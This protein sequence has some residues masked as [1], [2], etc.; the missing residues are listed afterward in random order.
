MRSCR[1]GLRVRRN[2]SRSLGERLIRSLILAVYYLVAITIVGIIGIPLTFITGDI[3]WMYWRA[4][5]CAL[6]GV[7]MVGAEV[8]TVG[9]D[10]FDHAGTYIY[11]FNH[12]SN[13]DPPIVVPLIPRRTSVLVKKEV[14]RIPILS[15]AMRMAKFVPVDRRNRENAVNSVKAAVEVMREGVNMA[16]FPEG[17][18]SPDA[19]LLPFKKGPFHLAMESGVSVLPVSIHGTEKMMGKGTLKIKPGKVTVVYHQPISPKDFKDKEGLMAATR[20]AI[21]SGLPPEM[22]G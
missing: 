1:S 6:F 15:R 14:F 10:S 3:T 7:K 4:M 2:E 11:M 12:I 16:V 5:R 9:R 22:R 8:E 20:A 21:A 17:T 18:R 13:L 19:K